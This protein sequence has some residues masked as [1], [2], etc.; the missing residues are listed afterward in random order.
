MGVYDLA[1][2][3]KKMCLGTF[4]YMVGLWWYCLRRF[5]EWLVFNVVMYV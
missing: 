1:T 2:I 4:V 5:I 3:N